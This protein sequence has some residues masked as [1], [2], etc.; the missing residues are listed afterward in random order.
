MSAISN[1]HAKIAPKPS[2]TAY[3]FGKKHPIDKA[4]SVADEDRH[5]VDIDSGKQTQCL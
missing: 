4:V 2:I 5:M 1:T 3:R